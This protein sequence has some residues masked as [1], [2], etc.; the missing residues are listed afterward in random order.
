MA[1]EIKFRGWDR[2]YKEM[3]FFSLRFLI[4]NINDEMTSFGDGNFDEL[5]VMQYTGLKDKNG[6]DIFEGDILRQDICNEFG[7][8]VKN[9][10]GQMVWHEH[11]MWAIKYEDDSPMNFDGDCPPPEVIGNIWENP[12]LLK[13]Q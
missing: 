5:E 7:S 4:E 10:I 8:M 1:R 2:K 13:K 3:S 6:L 12:E 9:Q 11:G